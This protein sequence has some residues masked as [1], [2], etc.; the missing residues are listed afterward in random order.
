LTR[1]IALEGFS[2]F[3]RRERFKSYIIYTIFENAVFWD[4]T[5]CF[6]YE[7]INVFKQHYPED[8][9]SKFIQDA[10]T[11]LPEYM[12]PHPRGHI[13]DMQRRKNIKYRVYISSIVFHLVTR[14]E[15]FK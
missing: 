10:G 4:A 7:V 8:G 5:S 9:G 2:K 15:N 12:A 13:F 6:L 14:S 3:I 1:L 11:Y